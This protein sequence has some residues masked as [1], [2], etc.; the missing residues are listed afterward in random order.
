[1]TLESTRAEPLLTSAFDYPLPA[2]RIAQ[3]P[4]AERDASRLLLVGQDGAVS[5]HR[6]TDL[7][8]LLQPGDLLVANETRVRHARLHGRVNGGRAVELL[9]VERREDG[10]YLCL[11]R[12]SRHLPAGSRV[13]LGGELQATVIAE[14][15]EHAGGRI[16]RFHA[17][18]VDAAIERTGVAPLPP[19]IH[20][21]LDEPERYQTTYAT[22]PAASAAAPTAGLHFTDAVLNGLRERGIGWST[23]RLQVG[24]ATFAP[25]RTRRVEAHE[26][27]AEAFDLPEATAAAIR[28]TRQAGGRVVAV[29]TTVTRV[30]ETCAEED[31]TVKAGSG[32]TRLFIQPG[33]RFRAVDGLLTNFHQPRSSLLVLLASLI[34]MDAWRDAYEHALRN[35]YR[36]LSFGDCM[37]CWSANR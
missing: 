1:M 26:M 33:H 10:D 4:L 25:I 24:L 20:R 31:G 21:R 7:P 36:F 35:G 22:G 29:G 9:A 16:V 8:S 6:F 32:T 5:D 2:D 28:R 15:G 3:E 11:A 30:L 37:L 13:T 34:G 27:H 18:D 19:Y 14:S 17:D 12:P 23:V